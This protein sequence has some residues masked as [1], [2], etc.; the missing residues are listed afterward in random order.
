MVD[1]EK[2]IKEMMIKLSNLGV[3]FKYNENDDTYYTSV[4]NVDDIVFYINR[5]NSYDLIN[6]K[7]IKCLNYVDELLEKE[8][9]FNRDLFKEMAY[10]FN[11]VNLEY[12]EI[13]E[14]AYWK[15]RCLLSEKCL[16][17]SP[18]DTDIDEEQIIAFSNYNNFIGLYGKL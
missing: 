15:D 18:C 16:E 14:L 8:K 7:L 4:K 13:T 3:K 11:N 12:G 9:L 6:I 10:L 2:D 1:I 17:A 5:T